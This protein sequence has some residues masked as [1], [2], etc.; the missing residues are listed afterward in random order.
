VTGAVRE[1]QIGG[2]GARPPAVT[3]NDGSIA[4]S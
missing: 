3:Q 2:A 4:K 1:E